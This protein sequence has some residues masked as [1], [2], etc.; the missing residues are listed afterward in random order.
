VAKK[1]SRVP[2]PPRSAQTSAPRP[3]QA[4]R[5]RKSA[6]GPKAPSDARRTR[7]VFIGLGGVLAVAALA[8]G[9]TTALGGGNDAN[10]AL[11]Q[12]GCTNVTLP[13]QGQQHV[14]ELPKG[15]KY[16]SFPPTSGPHDPVP[17]LWNIYDDPIALLKEVHNLEHGGIVIQYGDEVPQETIDRIRTW[18]LEDPTALLVAPL[19]SLGDKVTMTAWTHLATCP[20]FDESAADAFRDAHILKGPERFPAERLQPNM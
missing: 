9:L 6:G 17:A 4:P 13:S 18:Y 11:A 5:T 12:A 1:K 15:F 10:A 7:L 20:T 19:P 16:N 14:T 3:V 8:I 2:A